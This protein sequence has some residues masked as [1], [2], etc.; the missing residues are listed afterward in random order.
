[1]ISKEITVQEKCVTLILDNDAL[2]AEIL[3]LDGGRLISLTHKL[4]GREYIWTNPRTRGIL[5]Y[6]GANYDNLSA[7]GVEEAFPTGYQDCF[8]GDDLPF[9]GEIWPLIWQYSE[10]SMQNGWVLDTY[11]S[12][13]PVKVT[14]E[15]TLNESGLCCRYE[16]ENLS[17]RPLPYLF[18]VHPCLNIN[19]GDRLEL[20]SG[21]WA[22]G[23]TFP[24]G[25]L[26][27]EFEW[28]VSGMRDLSVL[29]DDNE[30]TDVS[31]GKA[32]YIHIYKSKADTGEFAIHTANKSLRVLYDSSYFT[33]LSIW[34]IYGGWRGH[35]CVMAEFFSG[36]PLKLS[37]AANQGNC[38]CLS[39]FGRV[40]TTVRY[41][42]E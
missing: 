29:P 24:D 16:L 28:P 13:Y 21:T 25:L 35:R 38:A 1:M 30:G 2:K 34:M 12:V 26:S 42:L 8:N 33:S 23:S 40:V 20:P 31:V 10:N 11:C 9:F 22:I 18:G 17:D 15:W 27:G 32:E 37:E 6:H 39:P 36:W 14:K 41:I 4:S 5:R 3:P 7:G 19:P